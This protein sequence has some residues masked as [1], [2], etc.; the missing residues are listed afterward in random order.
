MS[1]P[2]AASIGSADT[3]RRIENTKCQI[4]HLREIGGG[5]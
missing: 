3:L 4:F 1:L 5:G 2:K